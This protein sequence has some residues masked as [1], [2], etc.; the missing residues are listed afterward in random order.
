MNELETISKASA[1][2]DV[3]ALVQAIRLVAG[4]HGEINDRQAR[5]DRARLCVWDGMS[6]DGRKHAEDLGEEP[7]PFEGSTDSRVRVVDTVVRER[8]ALLFDAVMK[9]RPLVGAVEANDAELASRITNLVTW[10]RD[11]KLRPML[12]R[13][14]RLAAEY[15]VADSPAVCV[16]GVFWEQRAALAWREVSVKEIL[17]M[18]VMER[19][20]AAAQSGAQPNPAAILQAVQSEVDAVLAMSAEPDG[21]RV[22]V[23]QLLRMFPNA[24]RESLAGCVKDLREKGAGR[25]TE[26]Y[27][28]V[29]QPRWIA[30][31]LNVDIFMP[32]DDCDME[33]VPYVFVR[34]W[35]SRTEVENRALLEEWPDA[36]KEQVLKSN[37]QSLVPER[38]GADAQRRAPNSRLTP[39]ASAQ[40]SGTE[41]EERF[42]VWECYSRATDEG[43]VE[44]IYRTVLGAGG[45]PSSAE[46]SEG[47][48]LYGSH[49][50]LDYPHGEMPF[51]ILQEEVMSRSLLDS[52][53]ISELVGTHQ[54]EIKIQRD[55]RGDHSMLT[56][57]PPVKVHMRRGGLRLTVGPM[58]QVPVM[59]SDDIE[60]LDLGSSYPNTSIEMEAAVKGEV[61][62]LLA[63]RHPEAD[64][65]RVARE[66]SALV[67]VFMEGI[68]QAWVQ[69][70][71]LCQRFM[72]PMEMSRV[73]GG[74][75]VAWRMTREEIQGQFDLK[76]Y[77]DVRDANL[78]F[79]KMKL[80]WFM[81][82][83]EI[84][85]AG[86]INKGK[87]V[88]YGAYA[89]DAN[90]ADLV[91]MDE[92]GASEME[93]KDEQNA[94]NMMANG[95]EPDLARM[96]V[97]AQLRLATLQETI[98]RSRTLTQRYQ[99]G[100]EADPFRDLVDNRMK[101]LNFL[102]QQQGPNKQI[103]RQ[104]TKPVT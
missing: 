84:D 12:F 86:V 101:N 52:R 26:S 5:G 83:A 38:D 21:M 29:N 92:Q 89:M 13:E 97:N 80:E 30:Y 28:R 53:G 66:E 33:R 2:P 41:A 74:G 56:T 78:E 14:V 98:Q 64:P 46:A 94:V 68:S 24:R 15:F 60:K 11:Q 4:H 70:V 57:L 34:E 49:E 43:D 82:M 65:A 19:A 27:L 25:F 9:S 22:A 37:G 31:R 18:V 88:S 69:T 103:G 72:S 48:Q 67:A 35:L 55:T 51:V 45:A 77:I 44:G 40:M 91:I 75:N 58:A 81:R 95:I 59:R 17:E 36:F 93:R 16:L 10:L 3:K 32:T 71:K 87:L 73:T 8:K 6:E 7:H 96:G 79:L 62:E 42:E 1:V 23:E 102:L 20:Q 47:K 50:L 104:G 100:Q 99:A 61:N 76:F 54:T 63:R 39:G 85:T 90:L